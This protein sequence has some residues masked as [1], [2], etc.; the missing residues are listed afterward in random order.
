MARRFVSIGLLAG[1]FIAFAGGGSAQAAGQPITV[2]TLHFDTRVGPGRSTHCD[3]VGDLY[4]PRSAT[5]GHPAPAILTT[6]GFGGSKDDQKDEATAFARRGYVVLSYSGLGFGGSGCRIQLDDPAWDGR[7]AAQL[8]RFLG[9]GGRSKEGVRVN[10]VVHDPRAANG[11]HYKHDPRVGMIGGS[12][13]GQIQFAAAGAT[14]RL[15]TIVP[16]ITWNDLAYSLVPNNSA[17]RT[18]VSSSVP[19][20]PKFEWAA[21]FF[22]EGALVDG[23]TGLDTDP[24]RVTGCPNFDPGVCPAFVKNAALG[25]PDIQ[26]IN[27]LRHASVV[28]YMHKI[29]I[30]T[31]LAQGEND[32]LFNLH[33]AAA[34]YLALRHR[35]VPVGMIWQSWGHSSLGPAPGEIDLAHP[36]TSYEGRRF[37]RW[38]NYYLKDRGPRPALNFCY[39]RDWVRYT[40]A[41]TPAYGCAKRYPL[42]G[43]R[44]YFLSGSDA[45][46]ARRGDAKSGSATFAT[47][48]G[49]AATS[50][51][52][53]SGA[54]IVLGH[55]LAPPTDVPGAFAS[56]STPVL[57]HPVD[58]A[59]VP[60]LRVT[61]SDPVQAAGGG[62]PS[63]QATLF[64]K[65][66]DVA[67]DGTITLPD[68][69]V[70]PVRV[71]RVDNPISVSLPGIVHR[72][73]KGH[74]L[75]LVVAGGDQ[76]YRGNT[77]SSPVTVKTDAAHPA[78]LRLP[79][80][81]S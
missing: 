22:G 8:I 18:G 6:N 67:P 66:Y 45:L 21:L 81:G 65:L 61:I 43:E 38:F 30:P 46:V 26:T 9:G 68:R 60:K 40:G 28:S 73:P 33:E 53:T 63:T 80:A 70:S 17:L 48:P 24:G 2:R 11:R 16:I 15:D 27:L 39:F 71:P 47:S 14:P 58:V 75:E 59:G 31:L 76:A 10:Y 50:Y 79:L 1:A 74:R 41:A 36:N 42:R 13:G 25:Y 44:K 57:N 19:G 62:D 54:G 23:I 64:F 77:V 37:A 4:R 7:A 49:G 5:R 72:F 34:T 56:F 32:T 20:I 12:Y 51:S 35:H 3:V 69:L 78:R 55:E 29:R 52:E